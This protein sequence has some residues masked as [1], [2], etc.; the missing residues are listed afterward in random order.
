MTTEVLENQCPSEN[1]IS[2]FEKIKED[3]YGITDRIETN[4]DSL[5]K[6]KIYVRLINVIDIIE[7]HENELPPIQPKAK[8]GK[9]KNTRPSNMSDNIVCSVCGYDSIANYQYCPNCGAKMESEVEK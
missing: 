5:W 3:I 7:K 9:W 6:M 4:P 1:V 8:V 2:I